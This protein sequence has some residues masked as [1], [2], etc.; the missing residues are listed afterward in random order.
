MTVLDAATQPD[1]VAMVAGWRLHELKGN[2]AGRWSITVSGNL[3]T[4]P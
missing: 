4:A 3:G 2:E 1:D